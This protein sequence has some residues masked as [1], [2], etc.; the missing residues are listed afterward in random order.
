MTPPVLASLRGEDAQGG[1]KRT[2]PGDD[3]ISL[4]AHAAPVE[5]AGDGDVAEV[6]ASTTRLGSSS[7]R[8]ARGCEDAGRSGIDGGGK[9]GRPMGAD[10]HSEP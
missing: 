9:I 8:V 10:G 3:M 5:R 7:R 4:L 6:A 1:E 2:E